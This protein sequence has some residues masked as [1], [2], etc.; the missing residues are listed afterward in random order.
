MGTLSI[1]I[2]RTAEGRSG[3]RQR[4]TA[5]LCRDSLIAYTPGLDRIVE[6]RG[7]TRLG[8]I[9]AGLDS[10]FVAVLDDTVAVCPGWA[11]RLVRGLTRSGAAAIGPLSNGARGAQYRSGDYQDIPGFLRFAEQIA[12]AGGGRIEPVETLHPCCILSSCACLAEVDP[13]TT[14]ADLPRALR[15]AGRGMAVALD[16]YVHSFAAYYAQLRPEVAALI[17]QTASTILDVGCGTGALGAAL[18]QA[19]SVRV[20]GVEIDPVAAEAARRV[21]DDV[22]VGDIESLEWPREA[23]S[24]DAVVLA[25][26]LEHLRDPWGLLGRLAPLLAP[27]GRLIASLPNIRHWSV[28]GG[29]LEGEWTYL[30]AG[31]LDHG[32]LRFFTRTSGRALIESAGF[33]VMQIEPIRSAGIPDLTPLVEVCRGLSLDVSTLVEE[34]GVTQYLYVAAAAQ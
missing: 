22:Y 27:E 6:M 21:L 13:N 11:D 15:A 28:L 18:K 2:R 17:P 34:A 5:Q 30:P 1:V 31:I 10:P 23:A 20:I 32:H 12:R 3:G 4:L 19:R 8:E 29:L 16:T 7:D 24:F 33:R 26:I 25:D 14:P 9:R